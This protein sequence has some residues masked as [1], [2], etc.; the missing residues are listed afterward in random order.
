MSQ[1]ET[2][3][4]GPDGVW[5]PSVPLPMYGVFF[6]RCAGPRCRKAFRSED[7]YKAHYRESHTS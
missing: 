3:E 4:L 2:L 7:K 6:M 5:R 1:A